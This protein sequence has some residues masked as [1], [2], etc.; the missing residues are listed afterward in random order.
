MNDVTKGVL[1]T[2]CVAGAGALVVTQASK[3]FWKRVSYSLG[4]PDFRIAQNA[5]GK[6]VLQ[7]SQPLTI[8][9]KIKARIT[10]TGYDGKVLYQNIVIGTASITPI[11]VSNEAPATTTIFTDFTDDLGTVLGLTISDQWEILKIIQ[12]GLKTE[13]KLFIKFGKKSIAIPINEEIFFA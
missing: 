13:G 6:M 1:L 12:T 11:S 8:K 2:I 9:S 5:S 7:Y 10:A 4:T 3:A